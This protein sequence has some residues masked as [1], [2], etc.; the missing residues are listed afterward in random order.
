M[1]SLARRTRRAS[2]RISQR[3]FA[4]SQRSFEILQRCCGAGTAILMAASACSGGADPT[5]DASQAEEYTGPLMRPGQNCLSCHREDDERGAPVWTAAGTVYA[6]RDAPIAEGLPCVT[7]TLTGADGAEVVLTT[8]AAGNFYTPA[9]L[10]TP[11]TVELEY[12]GRTIS[13]PTAPPAGSCNACHAQPP[14]AD[15]P[16]RIYAP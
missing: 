15:A 9:P 13:M 4:I 5:G 11:F 8:N 14:I 3:F 16:G 2:L 7:V 1:T 12:E 6:S 10:L